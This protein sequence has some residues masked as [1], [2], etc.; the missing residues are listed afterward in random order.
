MSGSITLSLAGAES[1]S[2]DYAAP[3]WAAS[4][5][6]TLNLSGADLVFFDQRTVA[7]ASSDTIDVVGSLSTAL[8]TSFAAATFMGIAVI[9]KPKTGAANTTNLTIGNATNAFEGFLSSAGTIGPIPPGGMVL[10]A[11]SDLGTP[12]AGSTDEIKITNSSGASAIYQ[13][14]LFAASS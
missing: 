8:G 4:L 13:I 3:Q 11:G 12:S 14:A 5:S 9:N 6:E 1:G 2:N 7:S 10:V